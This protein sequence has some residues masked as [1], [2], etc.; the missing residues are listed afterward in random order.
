[1]PVSKKSMAQAAKV[2]LNA[3]ACDPESKSLGEHSIR[4]ALA[5]KATMAVFVPSGDGSKPVI[6]I[7]HNQYISIYLLYIILYNMTLYIYI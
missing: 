4:K 7:I 2:S 3:I 6:L 1:M 5:E